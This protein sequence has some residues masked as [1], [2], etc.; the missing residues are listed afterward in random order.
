M[1]CREDRKDVIT[2]HHHTLNKSLKE[3]PFARVG[4]AGD[5][6]T[7]KGR[8]SYSMISFFRCY[9][10]GGKGVRASECELQKHKEGENRER[11]MVMIS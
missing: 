4:P 2:Y 11:E 10:V 5:K 3:L 1:F 6:V 7:K 9:K 8:C